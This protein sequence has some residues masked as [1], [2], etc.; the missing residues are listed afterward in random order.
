MEFGP[1]VRELREAQR[2]SLRTVAKALELSAPY[3]SDMELGRRNP[4]GVEAVLVHWAQIIGAD[5][6]EL[7]GLAKAKRRPCPDCPLKEVTP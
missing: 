1:R 2:I 3:V 7:I 5:P 4:P 6:D